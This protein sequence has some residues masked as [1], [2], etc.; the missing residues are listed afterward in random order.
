MRLEIDTMVDDAI[1]KCA[2]E[3]TLQLST[4]RE[5]KNY[6]TPDGYVYDVHLF[7]YTLRLECLN[8]DSVVYETVE[9]ADYELGTADTG[10]FECMALDKL[11]HF[12]MPR[13]VRM[14]CWSYRTQNLAL[15]KGWGGVVALHANWARSFAVETNDN[16]EC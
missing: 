3:F 10:V 12:M 16:D 9:E 11:V 13:L 8:H 6:H 15:N 4:P 2:V 14:C 7:K 1:M 5:F